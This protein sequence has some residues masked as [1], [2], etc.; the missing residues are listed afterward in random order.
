MA[1]NLDTWYADITNTFLNS[2]LDEI[3]YCKFP[4][5]FTQAGKCLKLLRALYGLRRAPRLWQQEFTSFLK[6][7][8]LRQIEEEPC[9]F[10]NNKGIFLLFYVDDILL[11]SRK[12]CS[13]EAFRIRDALLQ[14]YDMKELG[15]LRWFLGIR[16]IRD[17]SQCKLWLCQDS[18][19]E[20]IIHKYNLQFQK[21][22][23]TPIYIDSLIPNTR[24]AIP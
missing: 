22:S 7:L 8:R 16:V 15:E 12:D 24:C 14:E 18:Y 13:Q 10:T 3:I 9:L 11:M 20:K 23:L 6:R 1:Y 4:N 21:H 17:Q 2:E 19:V 5:G